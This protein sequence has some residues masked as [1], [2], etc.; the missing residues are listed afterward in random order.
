[1]ATEEISATE[2]K[3]DLKRILSS[4]RLNPE[5]DSPAPMI[6]EGLELDASVKREEDRF[7]SGLAAMLLNID[8]SQ[9]SRFDKAQ[10]LKILA[11]I[12]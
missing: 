12:D 1:M 11:R 7:L 5:V 3:I 2:E 9:P 10:V 4:V 8:T 6:K